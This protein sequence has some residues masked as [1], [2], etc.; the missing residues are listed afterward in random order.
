MYLL[1]THAQPWPL[2]TS[3][4][5]TLPPGSIGADLG[6][7]NGKYLHLRSLLATPHS[8]HTDRAIITFGL[9][10]SSNLIDIAVSNVPQH[11]SSLLPDSI[12]NE[13]CVGDAL[14]SGYRSAS[15][16]FAM[17]IATIHHFA[18]E[19]RRCEAVQELIRIVRPVPRTKSTSD[20]Q[21]SA[22]GSSTGSGPGRFMIYVW[23]LEQR[24]E[25]RR[26][27]EGV[28][29]T[30]ASNTDGQPEAQ[31][32]EPSAPAAAAAEQD[33]LVPWVTS[34]SSSS[35]SGPASKDGP[36][37]DSNGTIAS[38]SADQQPAVFQRFY[39]VFRQG[40]L[41]DLVQKAASGL[42]EEAQRTGAIQIPEVRLQGSGWERGNWWGVWRVESSS[43]S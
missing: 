13:V 42:R 30:S 15:M 23:A 14:L 3:F 5:A 33:L 1:H 24:G 10:R 12:R 7:G 17:S 37:K 25:S 32:E 27:F 40:E 2:V 38:T 20:S 11:K 31:P 28:S 19:Q 43:K 9:D 35:S 16:D 26:N 6:C 4:L 8:A 41:E 39:H 29:T 22:P 34:S 36:S 18:T 21:E